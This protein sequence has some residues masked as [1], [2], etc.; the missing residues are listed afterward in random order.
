MLIWFYSCMLRSTKGV[1]ISR[2]NDD[3]DR[4]LQRLI[5]KTTKDGFFYVSMCFY[6]NK[7]MKK[8][9][10]LSKTSAP[11]FSKGLR[12]L[13]TDILLRLQKG[14]KQIYV[15][16]KRDVSLLLFTNWKYEENKKHLLR[17][18]DWSNFRRLERCTGR[19]L[20]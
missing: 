12:L 5:K 2:I 17:R 8:N 19:N 3:D 14:A 4:L 6:E 18:F 11:I 15:Y 9:R 20:F 1:Y 13:W 16:T 7:K 10:N